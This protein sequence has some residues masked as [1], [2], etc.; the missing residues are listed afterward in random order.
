MNVVRDTVLCVYAAEYGWGT[1]VNR[2][3]KPALGPIT[4]SHIPSTIIVQFFSI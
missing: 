1:S 4:C 2:V 3:C